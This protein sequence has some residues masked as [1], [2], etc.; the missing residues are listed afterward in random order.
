MTVVEPFPGLF[1]S[2]GDEAQGLVAL[3]SKHCATALNAVLVNALPRLD[4]SSSVCQALPEGATGAL[5][6]WA[7]W[8]E[9][10]R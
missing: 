8:K 6:R 2:A 5:P 10:E 1:S 4:C 7:W 3:I 9:W